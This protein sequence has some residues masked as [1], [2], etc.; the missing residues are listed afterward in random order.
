MTETTPPIPDIKRSPEIPAYTEGLVGL[1][2]RLLLT[3]TALNPENTTITQITPDQIKNFPERDYSAYHKVSRNERKEYWNKQKPESTFSAQ[4]EDWA[5]SNT[6]LFT[7]ESSAPILERLTTLQAATGINL[8]AFS[9]EEADKLYKK[10]FSSSSVDKDGS[11]SNIKLFVNDVLSSYVKDNTFDYTK[12]KEDLPAIQWLSNLFGE[13]GSE[14]VVQLI[15]SEAKLLLKDKSEELVKQANEQDRINHLDEDEKRIL[16][17]I[18]DGANAAQSEE[19]IVTEPQPKPPAP[20]EPGPKPTDTHPTGEPQ[21]YPTKD[22]IMVGYSRMDK[23]RIYPSESMLDE[24]QD[25]DNIAKLIKE[26]DP[27]KYGSVDASL[28]A[29][30]IRSEEQN[31]DQWMANMGLSSEVLEK[32][33]V[34]NLA[35]Y[36]SFLKKEYGVEIPDIKHAK[37]IP[38]V[39]LKRST[40]CPPDAFAFVHPEMPAIFINF[41]KI[42]N[43][44]EDMTLE[45][46]PVVTPEALRKNIINLLHEV[47][48][49]EY[50]HLTSDIAYWY[51]QK[52]ESDESKKNRDVLPGKVGIKVGKPTKIDADGK[53]IEAQERGR[54]LMEAVTVQLTDQWA[55]SFDS[56]LDIP[57]YSDERKVLHTIC[58]K[59][60]KEDGVTPHDVFKYFV[61]GYYSPEGFR[62]MA[63]TLSGKTVDETTKKIHFKRP[64]FLPIVYGLMEYESI[65]AKQNKKNPDYQLTIDFV[66]GTLSADQKQSLQ[67]VVQT[68]QVAEALQL[69]PSSLRVI[70]NLAGIEAPKKDATPDPTEVK[71]D[72]SLQLLGQGGDGLRIIIPPA[73]FEKANIDLKKRSRE[74]IGLFYPKKIFVQQG[75]FFVGKRYKTPEGVLCSEVVDYY[76]AKHNQKKDKDSITFSPKTYQEIKSI[77]DKLNIGIDNEDEKYSLIGWAH[78]HPKGA[79]GVMTE[80]DDEITKASF[81]EPGQFAYVYAAGPE[82]SKK[83]D[84]GKV[85]IKDQREDVWTGCPQNVETTCAFFSQLGDIKDKK[86]GSFTKHRGIYLKQA[87]KKKAS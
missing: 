43:Y 66:N 19:P 82:Y 11:P 78:T 32:I 52:D 22:G 47:N 67:K 73:I 23:S 59:L 85:I 8:K 76:P 27:A 1:Q 5:S 24:I 7:K 64:S 20:P 79:M 16:K 62:N 71:P 49:H 39:G 17:Y 74:R 38:L 25:T 9:R 13:T 75:G 2:A 3:G 28:I 83:D 86:I 12:L 77:I 46:Y 26:S 18:W 6:A 69:S 54:G 53:I 41:D 61:N 45:K 68:P 56:S 40:L 4:Y 21:M 10:Y 42:V 14:L 63:E 87:P 84:K 34:D 51:T 80:D 15:D 35:D 37:V 29:Q 60:A 50:T 57:A 44:A 33:I 65:L 30:K 31:F 48:P 81:S 58:N 55:K 72:E 70:A 36:T